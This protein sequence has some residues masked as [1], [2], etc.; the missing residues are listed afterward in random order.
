MIKWQVGETSGWPKAL[1]AGSFL[2]KK[3][4]VKKRAKSKRRRKERKTKKKT[5]ADIIN[6]HTQVNGSIY[7]Q[8]NGSIPYK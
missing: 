5:W 2:I 8:V 6:I 4:K 1:G 3:Q 7:T